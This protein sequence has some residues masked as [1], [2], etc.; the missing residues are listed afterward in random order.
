MTIVQWLGVGVVRVGGTCGR[1]GTV[2]QNNGGGGGLVIEDGGGAGDPSEQA[3]RICDET[4]AVGGAGVMTYTV[5]EGSTF[6]GVV[7]DGGPGSGDGR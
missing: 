6:E 5:P 4:F 7:G 1:S 3:A 2:N